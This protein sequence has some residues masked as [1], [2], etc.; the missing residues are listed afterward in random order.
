MALGAEDRPPERGNEGVKLVSKNV[1][2]S[3]KILREIYEV[4]DRN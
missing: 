3:L 4:I 1:L 2:R